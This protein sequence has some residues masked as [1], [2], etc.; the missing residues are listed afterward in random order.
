MLQYFTGGS[1]TGLAY[2]GCI[3]MNLSE[4]REQKSLLGLTAVDRNLAPTT[5]TPLL[6]SRLWNA[7]RGPQW[8][9]LGGLETLHSFGR[10][11]FE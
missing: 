4:P 10:D 9:P 2:H 6:G 3:N 7:I 5:I 8:R 11:H 1:N